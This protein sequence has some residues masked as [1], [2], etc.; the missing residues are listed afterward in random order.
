[1]AAR[2]IKT[3]TKT[4]TKPLSKPAAADEV[5]AEAAPDSYG[6][7][8]RPETGRYLLQVDRQTKGSY[9]ALDAAVKAGTAIKIAHPTVQVGVYDAIDCV[10]TPVEAAS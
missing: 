10:N 8:K 1:M 7:R 9:V 4:L 5:S 3:L 2:E 6:Q